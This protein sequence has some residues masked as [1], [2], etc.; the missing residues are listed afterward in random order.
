MSAK[1]I[2]KAIVRTA[3]KAKTA[4]LQ[5]ANMV[6]KAVAPNSKVSKAIDSVANPKILKNKGGRVGLKHGGQPS[7][8]HGECPKAK[9]N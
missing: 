2:G 8:K 9:A 6:G 1:N 3:Y 5:A 4:P 7:Y